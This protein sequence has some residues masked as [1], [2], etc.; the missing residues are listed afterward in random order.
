MKGKNTRKITAAMLTAVMAVS[1]VP[2]TNLSADVSEN[3]AISAQAASDHTDYQS[4]GNYYRY[5]KNNV[6]SYEDGRYKFPDIYIFS[7][8]NYDY[9]NYSVGF[10]IMGYLVANNALGGPG[11][12]IIMEDSY[13]ED[14]RFA[15]LVNDK[16]GWP[17]DEGEMS[18]N[19]GAYAYYE[20]GSGRMWYTDK[21]FTRVWYYEDGDRVYGWKGSLE[22]L[23]DDYYYL[24]EISEIES[25]KY[26]YL[27]KVDKESGIEKRYDAESGYSI[28]DVFTEEQL[29]KAVDS[30]P[31]NPEDDLINTHINFFATSDMTFTKGIDI[32]ECR[33]VEIINMIT[34]NTIYGGDVVNLFRIENGC[35]AVIRNFHFENGYAKD[36]GAIYNEGDLYL[37]NST[38]QNCNAISGGAVYNAKDASLK[39]LGTGTYLRY[40]NANYGGAV[41][42][43]GIAYM[44]NNDVGR[45]PSLRINNCSVTRNGGGIFNNGEL[46]VYSDTYIYDNKATTSNDESSENQGGA[47]YN[48]GIAYVHGVRI[49]NNHADNGGGGIYNS[50]ELHLNGTN[51]TDNYATEKGAGVYASAKVCLDGALNITGNK[52]V[53]NSVGQTQK[54]KDSNIY[55]DTYAS[56]GVVNK[57]YLLIED[58]D[59]TGTGIHGSIMG[60]T[61]AD[62]VRDF[63]TNY[64]KIHEDV[65]PST[66]FTSDDPD[67]DVIWNKKQTEATLGQQRVER[68]AGTTLSLEGEIC[69]NF[70]MQLEDSILKDKSA[71]MEFAVP[72]KNEG[73]YEIRKVMVS[74]AAEFKYGDN[75]YY[76]FKCRV[77]AKMMASTVRAQLVYNEGLKK[78]KNYT[79]DIKGY[80]QSIIDNDDD[81]EAYEKATPMMEA[82]LNYGAYAQVAFNYNTDNLANEYCEKKP[83]ISA[84]VSALKKWDYNNYKSENLPED[85]QYEDS[86]L[87]L[88][89]M[90]N[91]MMYFKSWD[92]INAELTSYG[93][94]RKSNST[95]DYL[96]YIKFEN[97]KPNEYDQILD[98][99]INDDY[100]IKYCPLTSCYNVLTSKLG[101]NE[102]NVAAALYEYYVAVKD[103]SLSAANS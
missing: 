52:I 6:E 23:N 103:Y 50:S 51:I 5:Y 69:I 18:E 36:G 86:T 21:N 9:N 100:S 80:A 16:F 59:N 35:N 66:Y 31:A 4:N 22:Q 26:K 29:R 58:P 38:F 48:S 37:Y 91:L 41:Y 46:H 73:E 94:T 34:K 75:T 97:I 84:A 54:I 11:K 49:F 2:F 42:N 82:M 56:N 27:L 17:R 62:G 95:G 47:V 40:C 30:A 20:D 45:K 28:L 76:T 7:S 67:Y 83:D 1:A 90:V 102:K 78:G 13:K 57:T 25:G 12:E 65:H 64:S 101:D 72:T 70:Q 19:V 44:S 10:K 81:S 63:T 8:N 89:S 32:T 85:I 43:E 3:N 87:E 15:D 39:I 96:K 60:V 98:V 92:G 55:I 99:K 79:Y 61:I 93:V 53:D 71:Y 33:N 14:P 74:D 88:G 77:P 68:L 24:K